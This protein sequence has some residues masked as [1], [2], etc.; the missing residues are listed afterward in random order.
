ELIAENPACPS[1]VDAFARQI[2]AAGQ[3][4][5][6]LAKEL[7]G[8]ARPGPQSSR[9]VCPAEVLTSQL[10]VLQAAAGERH[11]ITLELRSAAGRVLIDPPQLERVVLNL[12]VNARDAM[13]AGG[14]IGV[15]V[16]AVVA[17]DDD[18]KPG[19]CVLIAVSDCG[20][21]I[22]PAVLARIFDPFFT[23]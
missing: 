14:P 17:R 8:F 11:P 10:V 2:T 3:R 13:A 16:D 6:A 19:P 22:S 15:V 20:I 5:A 9:V 23:T 18:G 4:G 1:E 21:G 7:M 12:V